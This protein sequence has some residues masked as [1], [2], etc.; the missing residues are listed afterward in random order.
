MKIED[1][2]PT[3][4]QCKKLL[5]LGVDITTIFTWNKLTTG[6]YLWPLGADFVEVG[7]GY[8]IEQIPAPTVA[9]LGVLLGNYSVMKYQA[10]INWRLYDKI[11][12]LK[13]WL[14]QTEFEA[15]SRAEALI[16]LIEN[17]Y[18][19]AEDLRL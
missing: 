2:V 16:W 6:Y 19:K 10:D 13:H 14:S 7:N 17:G 9:E 11:G 3:P 12:M 1:Q 15:Q 4:E 5:S 18:V 8:I